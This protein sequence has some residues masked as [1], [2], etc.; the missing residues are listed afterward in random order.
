MRESYLLILEHVLEGQVHR[1]TPVGTKLEGAISPSYP[2]VQT[3]GH[4]EEPVQ[5]GIHDLICLSQDPPFPIT[6]A[7]VLVLWV[8]SLRILAQN[9]PKPRLLTCASIPVK[10]VAPQKIKAN[11]VK[12]AHPTSPEDQTLFTIGKQ[13]HCR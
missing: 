13:S 8:P 3:H 4:L 7:S 5:H 12:T 1:D 9:L 11:L 10:T 6:L 2:P